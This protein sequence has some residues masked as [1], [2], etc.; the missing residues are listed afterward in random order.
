[1]LK[2]DNLVVNYGYIQA[3]RDVSLEIKENEIITL[4]GGNGAGKS[5]T[6]MAISNLVKKTSGTVTF[7]GRDISR[8]D[9]DKIVSLGIAH[10]PEGRNIFKKLSVEENLLIGTIT[11]KKISKKEIN[12]RVEEMFVIFP[13]LKERRKKSGGSLS[14]GEQQMLA[15]ARGLMLKPRLLMMDEPSLGLAPII[16]EEIFELM[17]D[18]KKSGMTILLIE[19][20]AMLAL[21]VADRGYVLQNGEIVLTG[22]GKELLDNPE[23]KKA[24]LGI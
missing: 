16:V 13:R 24:Y 9:P 14:G 2:V 15:I 6:L 22:T 21:N 18:V 11:N 12:D 1:M 10:V 17:E 8:M 20:N 7:D 4:I 5:S 3:L 23:V 19:Q